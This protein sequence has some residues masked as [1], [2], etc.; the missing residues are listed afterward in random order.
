M[1]STSVLASDY[2]LMLVPDGIFVYDQYTEREGQFPSSFTA[3]DDPEQNP[4]RPKG[5]LWL[6]L[7]EENT[8]KVWKELCYER[9]DKK[10]GIK[11]VYIQKFRKKNFADYL[12]TK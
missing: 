5:F 8:I 7:E 4:E 11:L 10:G 9:M 3:V 6:K 2:D 12:V 1:P